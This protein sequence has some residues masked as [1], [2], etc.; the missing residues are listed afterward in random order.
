MNLSCAKFLTVAITV[1]FC[2]SLGQ[3][4]NS[5]LNTQ[6]NFS[7]AEKLPFSNSVDMLHNMLHGATNKSTHN[8]IENIVAKNQTELDYNF[9]YKQSS[10]SPT[11]Q[12]F[13]ETTRSYIRSA[14]RTYLVLNPEITFVQCLVKQLYIT[15]PDLVHFFQFKNLSKFMRSMYVVFVKFMNNIINADLFT[16]SDTMVEDRKRIEYKIAKMTAEKYAPRQKTLKSHNVPV[17]ISIIDPFDPNTNSRRRYQRQAIMSGMNVGYPPHERN[18]DNHHDHRMEHIDPKQD[19]NNAYVNEEMDPDAEIDLSNKA[20]EREADKLFNID[21][22]FWK[23][24]GIEENSLK[25]YSLAYCTKE[26]ATDLFRRFVR[27]VLLN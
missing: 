4:D 25:K 18:H 14:Y 5:E 6:V 10:A 15:N 13:F 7:H 22:M 16:W 8:N 11:L 21:A 26:Y 27:N 23:S 17:I 20:I 9:L 24:F 3:C 19:I 1:L 2:V 12:S